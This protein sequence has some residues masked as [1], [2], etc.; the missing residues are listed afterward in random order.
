MTKPDVFQLIDLDRTL[1]DTARFSLAITEEVEKTEQGVGEQLEQLVE[2]AYAKEQ[3]FF[4]MR[5][6][7]ETHGQEWFD[8]LVNRVVETYGADALKLPDVDERL[9]FADTLTDR[10]PAWGILTY[11]DEIDQRMKLRLIGLEG[12]PVVFT[13]TPDKGEVLQGWKTDEGDFQLPAEFG[14]TRVAELTFE[15]DKLRAFYHLPEG[16]TGYWV[17]KD[18]E[19]RQRLSRAQRGGE[20]PAHVTAVSGLHEIIKHLKQR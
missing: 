13:P 18:P 14:G 20:I 4:L 3:T 15:D 9:A 7:R 17:S 12:A 10:R 8:A 11:G 6:L 16:I 19:A 5:Y 1:F 2:A